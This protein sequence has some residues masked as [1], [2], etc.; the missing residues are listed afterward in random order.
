[1]FTTSNA[2]QNAGGTTPTLQYQQ[3]DMGQKTQVK[4]IDNTQI[5]IS[6]HQQVITVFNNFMEKIRKIIK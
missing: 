4:T 2:L 6:Q 5:K 1:M 3:A